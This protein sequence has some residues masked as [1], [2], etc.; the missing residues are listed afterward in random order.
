MATVVGLTDVRIRLEARSPHRQTAPNGRDRSQVLRAFRCGRLRASSLRL[1][2]IS[3]GVGLGIVALAVFDAGGLWELVRDAGEIAR[4]LPLQLVWLYVVVPAAFWLA[5]VAWSAIQH[6]ERRL[7]PKGGGRYAGRRRSPGAFRHRP[8]SDPSPPTPPPARS[9]AR[10]E[11]SPSPVARPA[12]R[13]A[14][15]ASGVA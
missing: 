4:R 15:D 5:V 1:R 3:A 14:S 11:L 10:G 13:P 9:G 7:L 12:C 6:R 8:G 2:V